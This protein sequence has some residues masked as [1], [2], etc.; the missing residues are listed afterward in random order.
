MF[1]YSYKDII[2]CINNTTY[3]QLILDSIIIFCKS[4]TIKISLLKNKFSPSRK[5]NYFVISSIID[6]F[7]FI[8]PFFRRV[9]KIAKSDY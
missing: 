5:I 6:F 1:S 8:L 4:P 7:D 3:Y 2:H 9:R